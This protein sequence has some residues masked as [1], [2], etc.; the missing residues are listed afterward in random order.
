MIHGK[1]YFSSVY[2]YIYTNNIL[3]DSSIYYSTIEHF[4]NCTNLYQLPIEEWTFNE[5]DVN[6]VEYLEL[7][8]SYYGSEYE[9]NINTNINSSN[10]DDDNSDDDDV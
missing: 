5:Y 9:Q 2:I 10:D 6:Y 3:N 1:F 4:N 8:Y 7:L